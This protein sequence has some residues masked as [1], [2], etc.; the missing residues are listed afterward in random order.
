MPFTRGA[1]ASRK[2]YHIFEEVN[3][4]VENGCKE[5][6]LLG[7]NVN[8]YHGVDKYNNEVNLAKLIISLEKIKDLKRISYTTS[9][10]IDM[11]EELI[12]LHGYSKKLNPYLHLIICVHQQTYQDTKIYK[13]YMQRKV[14]QKS[15]LLLK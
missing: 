6:V 15:K 10:P 2:S 7:Q 8:A 3:H 5:V 14:L 11:N 9:H 12:E 4:L 13:L 1:E